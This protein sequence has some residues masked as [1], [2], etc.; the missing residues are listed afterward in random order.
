M[1]PSVAMLSEDTEAQEVFSA[2]K[3]LSNGLKVI[4]LY[5]VSNAPAEVILDEAATMGADYLI[6]GGSARGKMVK[7]LK[8]NVIEEVAKQL[9]E[10]IKLIIYG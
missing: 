3:T 5:A 6:L 10:E 9:P 1:L 4:P 7:L 2:A 8:G